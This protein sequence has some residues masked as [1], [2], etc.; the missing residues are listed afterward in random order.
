MLT[1]GHQEELGAEGQGGD[2][3]QK[4]HR[5]REAIEWIEND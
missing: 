1:D 2:A 5:P 4:A 3:I